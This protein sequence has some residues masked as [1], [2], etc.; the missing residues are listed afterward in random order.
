MSGTAGGS[1]GGTVA[2]DPYAKGFAAQEAAPGGGFTGIDPDGPAFLASLGGLVGKSGAAVDVVLPGRPAEARQMC[3]A[4]LR[5]LRADRIAELRLLRTTAA[6]AGGTARDLAPDPECTA[7]LRVTDTPIPE[8]VIVNGRSAL[9]RSGGPSGR[10]ASLVHAPDVVGTLQAL[11][12]GVWRTAVPADGPRGDPAFEL[13]EGAYRVLRQM[14]TGDTDTAAA[15]ELS[16]SVRTY[17]RHAAEILRVL[18]VTSR[19]QAGVRAMELGLLSSC[20]PL[21]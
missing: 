13:S 1:G 21:R 12:S 10:R 16:I 4:L 6:P 5:L 20:G 11:F 8:V 15:R 9:V 19:F 14:C 3:A 7:R 2:A 17:R 18:G